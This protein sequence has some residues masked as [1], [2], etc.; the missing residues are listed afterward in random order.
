MNITVILHTTEGNVRTSFGPNC[1]Q[2]AFS[3]V[4][5]YLNDGKNFSI[6]QKKF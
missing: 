3:L 4:T 6:E 5:Q 2:H 1:E